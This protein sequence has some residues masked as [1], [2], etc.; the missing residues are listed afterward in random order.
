[1]RTLLLG[2]RDEGVDA[3]SVWR[4]R[5]RDGAQTL[6]FRALIKGRMYLA[7]GKG[8]GERARAPCSGEPVKKELTYSA[9]RRGGVGRPAHFTRPV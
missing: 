1:M 2:A 5:G 3:P 4:G 8:V 9:L 6:L 7:L